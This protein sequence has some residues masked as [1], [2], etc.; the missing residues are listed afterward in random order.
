MTF[1]VAVADRRRATHEDII[2]GRTFDDFREAKMFASK[3]AHDSDEAVLTNIDGE[4]VRVW[5][6][7]GNGDLLV[8]GELGA[9]IDAIPLREYLKK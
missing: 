5:K 3:L 9:W 6:W 8:T 2:K 7:D 1:Y 4:W